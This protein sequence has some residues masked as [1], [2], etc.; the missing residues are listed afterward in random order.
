MFDYIR[1]P[2]TKILDLS[3]VKISAKSFHEIPKERIELIEV[4]KI[5]GIKISQGDDGLY[6]YFSNDKPKLFDCWVI[7]PLVAIPLSPLT[8][9]NE[10][11][12]MEYPS[13]HTCCLLDNINVIIE[14]EFIDVSI[15]QNYQKPVDYQLIED[16]DELIYSAKN[17]YTL[18]IFKETKN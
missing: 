2:K 13:K 8:K 14:H 16:F 9:T 18:E 12:G 10:T 1:P 11:H 15:T 6:Y 5:S 3:D 7:K 4:S 17:I